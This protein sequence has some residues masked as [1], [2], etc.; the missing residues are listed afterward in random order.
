MVEHATMAEQDAA[1]EEWFASMDY[2]RAQRAKQEMKK[3]GNVGLRSLS[4][5][6]QYIQSRKNSFVS[7]GIWTGLLDEPG[8][9]KKMRII[10]QLE[11]AR[12]LVWYERYVGWCVGARSTFRQPALKPAIQSEPTNTLM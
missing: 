8:A 4:Q 9:L 7:G 10:V 6:T 5:H 3:K 11:Q 12:A 1:R 2:R